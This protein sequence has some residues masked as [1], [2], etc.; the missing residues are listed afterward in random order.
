MS[1]TYQP[2]TLLKKRFW[3]RCFALDF[4]KFLRTFFLKSRA[5]TRYADVIYYQLENIEPIRYNMAPVITGVV[6]I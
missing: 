5:S 2:E 1:N 4:A 6:S 3:H